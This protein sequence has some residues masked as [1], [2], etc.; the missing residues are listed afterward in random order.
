MRNVSRKRRLGM[1]ET[2]D[3][4]ERLLPAVRD[5]DVDE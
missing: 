4:T 5:T 3:T 1:G 2:S